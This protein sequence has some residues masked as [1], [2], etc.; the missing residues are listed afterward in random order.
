MLTLWE[1]FDEFDPQRSFGAWARGV[2]ANKI[3]QFRDRLGRVPTPFSPESIQAVVEAFDQH[4]LNSSEAA[5]AL[6]QCLEQLPPESRQVLNGWYAEAWSIERIAGQLGCT[7][8]AA[9]KML[10]RLRSRLLECVRRRLAGM[11][12]VRG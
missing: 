4:R 2:A 1:K 5:D 9:Y 11:Q 6:D 3:L 10:A 7:A 12:E 8:A